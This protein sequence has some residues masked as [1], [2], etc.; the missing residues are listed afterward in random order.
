MS[1]KAILFLVMGFSLIFLVLGQ[2][3]GKISTE[4]ITNSNNYYFSSI[5]HNLAES[6]ANIAASKIF[7]D[8]SWTTGYDHVDLDGGTYSVNVQILNAASN[9][10]RINS[11]G[12]FEGDTSIVQITLAPG[13]FAQYAYFS[14]IEPSGIWWTDGDTVWGKFHTQDYL[15]TAGHPVFMDKATSRKGIVYYHNK[16]T[17]SPIFMGGYGQADHK[18]P[19]TSI[20]DLE[21]TANSGGHTFMGNDTVSL[22]FVGDSIRY[23]TATNTTTTIHHH[24]TTTTTR[25]TQTVLA[26]TFAPNGVIFADNAV[27][28]IQGTVAGQYTVGASGT[29]YVDSYGYG[30]GTGNI[31]LDGDI[32][33]KTNPKTDPHSSDLFGIVAQQN[34][35]ITDNT[36]NNTGGGINIDGAIFC[37]D[38]GFGSENYKHRVIG[39]S[40]N[41]DGGITEHQRLAVGTFSYGG[42]IASGYN[43][44]YYFD[45]RLKNVSPPSFPTTGKFIILSWYE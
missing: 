15:R 41:L 9:I 39:G 26:S 43:K 20:S 5:S 45:K 12:I 11:T 40:I 31:Y 6:G 22:F 24:K 30:H 23:T 2:N 8:P 33:Y 34:V 36:A 3:F 38:G 1:G 19:S 18:I 37:Q 16:H 35:L 10:R 27:L 25:I 21:N 28:R 17:D 29:G 7:F 44:R 14:E 4:G 42:S 13:S 32:T